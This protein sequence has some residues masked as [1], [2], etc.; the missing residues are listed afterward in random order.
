MSRTLTTP[1]ADAGYPAHPV[2]S[3]LKLPEV[4]RVTGYRRSTIYRLMAEGAFPARVRLRPHG[5]AVGWPASAVQ[6]WVR[7]RI[8]ESRTT[9]VR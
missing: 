4:C 2:E 9:P 6:A 7:A 8:A 1:P 3:L 5:R